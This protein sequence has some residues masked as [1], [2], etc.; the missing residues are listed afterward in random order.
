M[1][2]GFLNSLDVEL[3]SDLSEGKWRLKA[4]LFFQSSTLNQ[5]ITV[6]QG[7]VTDFASVPR[8]PLAFL[9]AGDTAHRPA[10]VHDYLYSCSDVERSDADSVFLEAMDSV[11]VPWWRRRIMWAAVRCFGWSRKTNKRKLK[12]DQNETVQLA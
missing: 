10:V 6:P 8:L 1:T 9:L 4:P 12:G 11:G 3:V 5:I 2:S 7:F